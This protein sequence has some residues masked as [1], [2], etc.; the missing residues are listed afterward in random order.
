MADIQAKVQDLLNRVVAEGRETGVQVA[1]YH[2]GRF[3]VDAWA[4]VANRETGQRV[5]AHTLF[6]VFSTTKGLAATIAHRLA[7]RGFFS[8]EDPV[9]KYWPAFGQVGKDS[10]TVRHALSHSS[11]MPHMNAD[12]SLEVLH[13]WDAACASYATMAPLYP[14]GSKIEYH[15]VTFSWIVGEVLCRA[16]KKSIGELFA[17]E[18][19]TPLGLRDSFVGL[20]AE[21]DARVAILYSEPTQPF[22]ANAQGAYTI[23]HCMYPL[24]EWMNSLGARRCCLPSSN[25]IANARDIAKH[26]AALLPGGVDGV[27]LLAPETLRAATTLQNSMGVPED[28]L[29]GRFGLGYQVGGK[30]GMLGKR[31]SA[32]GHGGYGGSIGLADPETGFALGLTKNYYGKSPAH[33]EIVSAV[34]EALGIG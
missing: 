11:G 15:A 28:K 25:G 33:G 19:C 2:R 9:T 7:E 27:A 3:V 6:P 34:R 23:P 24:H 12:I 8:Y 29:P 32:F 21:E 22:S 17:R 16:A 26:Y 1:A 10:I 31:A 18:I 14:A 30:D 4:G 20:P 13:D 5:D